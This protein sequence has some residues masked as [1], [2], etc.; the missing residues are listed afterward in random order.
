MA[1]RRPLVFLG[2]RPNK[3]PTGD[4]LPLDMLPAAQLSALRGARPRIASPNWVLAASRYASG[5]ASQDNT[6]SLITSAYAPF[7]AV[8]VVFCNPT[9]SA[10]TVDNCAV[11]A[12]ANAASAV[13]PTGAWSTPTGL[14]TVPAGTPANP[15]YALSPKI[16]LRSIAR[17]DGGTT[18]LLYTRC[19]FQTGNATYVYA[20]TGTNMN[21][22]TWAPRSEG[23]AFVSA[24]SPGNMVTA[25]GSWTTGTAH[26]TPFSMIAGV[27]YTYDTAAV[28]VMGCGDSLMAG[29][30]G[31][32]AYNAP[33]G[34]KAV[35][36]LAAAGRRCTWSNVGWSGQTIQ[37][38]NSRARRIVDSFS[39]GV[40]MLPSWSPNSPNA[41]QADW[42]TQWQ[43]I[44]D[45]AQYQ[46]GAGGQVLMLTPYVNNGLS[47]PQDGFR[48]TQRARVMAS[49]LP[50]ADIESAISDGAT[51][52]RWKAGLNQDVTHPNDAGHEAMVAPVT[53][54][55]AAMIP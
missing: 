11:A 29:D 20:S 52:A 49:G 23:H 17:N 36:R 34:F 53:T 32:F 4:T 13:Q 7:N 24:N 1:E 16:A 21:A 43:V 22:A 15:S 45:A 51:P 6:W 41:T 28:S 37:E 47:A 14:I 18:P 3:L 8:Q 9:A 26:A 39:P 31:A 48:L 19:Y 10:V 38:M 50:F 2:A 12:S 30:F 55:L 54:A 27:L 46:Q 42:D 40:L 44:M 25:P 5:G 35:A 33:F